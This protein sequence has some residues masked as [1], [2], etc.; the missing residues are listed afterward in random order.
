[1]PANKIS[2]NQELRLPDRQL[3]ESIGEIAVH[4]AKR[5]LLIQSTQKD[6]LNNFK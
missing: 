6:R 1:M 2:P 4:K 3:L 5:K